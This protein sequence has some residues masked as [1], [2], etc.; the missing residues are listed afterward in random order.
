MKKVNCWEFMKCGREPGGAWA[1][2]SGVCPAAID[3]SADGLNQGLNA[4]RICWAVAG[5]FCFEDVSG[6]LARKELACGDC[7]FYHLVRGEE[8]FLE[9][10]IM[11]P[12]QVG[13][14]GKKTSKSKSGTASGKRIKKA[15]PKPPARGARKPV[16]KKSVAGPA[17]K[18]VKPKSALKTTGLK[19]GKKR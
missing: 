11:K 4:G 16:S 17:R 7:E 6:S 12:E 5:T 3:E 13:G 1:E 15:A 10:S 9:F 2:K 8:G 19:A 14:V 18:T